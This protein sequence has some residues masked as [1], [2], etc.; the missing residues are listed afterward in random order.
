[1]AVPR[2]P[3]PVTTRT[4]HVFLASPGD[5]EEERHPVRGRR[6]G[7]LR[8]CRSGA[9]AGADHPADPRT[10]REVARP[11]YLPLGP[12]FRLADRRERIG[13]RG[14]AQL[15]SRAVGGDGLA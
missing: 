15:G 8:D 1:M 2:E 10:L 4:Y 9:A 6:L 7:E 12:P 14:G 3:A 5:M 11:G 13:H